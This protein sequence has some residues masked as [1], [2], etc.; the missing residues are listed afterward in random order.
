MLRSWRRW[1]GWTRNKGRQVERAP[2]QRPAVEQLEDRTLLSFVVATSFRIGFNFGL[3]TSAVAIATGDFNHDG[4]MD[5]VTA[6]APNMGFNTGNTVTLLLGNGNG[7]FQPPRVFPL[8]QTPV[9]ILAADLNGDGNLD[10]VT[11]NKNNTVSVLLGTGTG[12]FR[13]P[14]LVKVGPG[15]FVHEP[16]TYPAGPGPVALAV[17][18]FSGD[19]I[20]DLAIAD[21]GANQVSL[22]YGTGN[23]QFTPGVSIQLP[24]GGMLGTASL[25]G[26]AAWDFNGDGKMDIAT[27]SNTNFGQLD[28]SLNNGNGTYTTTGYKTGFTPGSLAL[29]DFN[30]DGTM[31]AVVGCA[32]PSNNGVSVLL[33]NSDGTF[34]PVVNYDVGSQTP[35]ALAVADLNNDGAPDII[36][37]NGQFAN[38]SVSVLM[39]NGNGTFGTLHVYTAGQNPVGVAVGDFNGDGYPDVVVAGSGTPVGSGPP[40]GTATLMI[41]NGD[42]TMI[43]SPDLV[44]TGPG[45]IVAGDFNGDHKQDLAVVTTLYTSQ[46]LSGIM[47]FPGQGNGS[48]GPQIFTQTPNAPT[49]LVMG[50][51][52]GDNKLDLAYITAPAGGAT[53]PG[54]VTILLGNGDGTFTAGNTYT[55]GTNP[56]WIIADDFN[57]DH[58]LDLAVADGGGV[59]LLLGNGDGTFGQ[60]VS[61]AAGGP[62]TYVASG[63]FNGDGV[64]DLAAVNGSGNSHTVT[65]V[66]GAPGP[67]GSVL[68]SQSMQI[69]TQTGPGSVGV[70]DFNG[71]KKP[72]LVVPTFFGPGAN[73]QVSVLKN[74]GNGLFG[75]V[76]SLLT[77][78][79]PIGVAVNDFNG[80]HRLDIAVVNNFGDDL[81]VYQGNGQFGFGLVGIFA[82]GDRPTW[83]T[84]ADFNGDGVPD[85]AVVNSN[86]HTV[87]LLETGVTTANHFRVTLGTT[88]A[89]AGK[90]VSVTVT[91][92]DQNNQIVTG[93]HG[94]V[95]F[96]SGDL[97]ATLPAPYHFTAADHGVHHFTLTLRSAGSIG[98]NVGDGNGTG[99]DTITVTPAAANHF[100]LSVSSGASADTAFGLTVTA[101]DPFQNVDTNYQGTVRFS[102]SVVAA[103][104]SLPVNYS[105]QPSDQGQASFS[106]TLNR[107][108]LQT[109]TVTDTANAKLTATA[110]VPVAPGALFD[111]L[112]S[113]IPL[114][115]VRNTP[116]TVTVTAVDQYGNRETG[117]LG[118][119]QFSNAGGT[120]AYPSSHQFASANQGRFAITVTFQTAGSSQSFTAT[121]QLTGDF[122]S[123]SGITVR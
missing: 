100:H 87:T 55:V 20:L 43:A 73:S 31:D 68:F 80:D 70:G 62:A 27:V 123:E 103:L 63:D 109:V 11:A 15:R 60:A 33:G 21:S 105:F 90:A 111:F 110:S 30:H 116:Y 13:L 29:G 106:V 6:D 18:D 57:G 49:G 36:T 48:F 112:V 35:A 99:S 98:V 85:L 78:S 122:G 101:L 41:G 39:N 54:S 3:N 28:I 53:G 38:N 16:P 92:L 102:S 66:L 120:A 26:I 117:Y 67:N 50:D 86:S 1:I 37:A 83:V 89:T 2:R 10:V 118:L 71:D 77:H 81:T 88:T 46:L 65:I 84:T 47:F 42:G 40:L 95:T 8:G 9:A 115:A 56:S 58:H 59:S 24:A 74:R 4:K 91:A 104:A 96:S 69:T 7:T 107:A 113:G 119:V 22:L 52:N 12:S 108:G 25:T 61:V 44:V 82:V 19:H 97:H 76:D 45:P 23:G 79:R 121:D 51:F 14:V 94:T 17:G 34:Q 5:I 32:F 93:Y 72:D 64:P 75:F 114:N